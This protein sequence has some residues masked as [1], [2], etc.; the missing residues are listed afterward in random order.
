MSLTLVVM[1]TIVS[2]FCILREVRE[3]GRETVFVTEA[4][5]IVTQGL[6][7]KIELRIRYI[8]QNKINT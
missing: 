6:N 4:V 3:L 8:T 5:F 7:P 2:R 1:V